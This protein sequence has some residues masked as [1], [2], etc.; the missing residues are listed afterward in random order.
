MGRGVQALSVR[1]ASNARRL[2]LRVSQQQWR[3]RR[4]FQRKSRLKRY[5]RQRLVPLPE[6][7]G[8]MLLPEVS[9]ALSTKKIDSRSARPAQM[10]SPG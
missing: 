7:C 2:L 4:Y 6:A 5:C 1:S 8:V 10:R 9:L 3:R